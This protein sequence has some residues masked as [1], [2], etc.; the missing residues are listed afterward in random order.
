MALT[1]VV[2]FLLVALLSWRFGVSRKAASALRTERDDL[3]SRLD[4]LRAAKDDNDAL[5]AQQIASLH[6]RL[7]AAEKD[8]NSLA[9]FVNIRDTA[10][11]ADRI[12]SEAAATLAAAENKAAES[13]AAARQEAARVTLEATAEAKQKRTEADLTIARASAQAAKVIDD[14]R[15][16]AEEIAGD[17]LRAVEDAD[18]LT[19]TAAAMKNVIDGYGDAYMIPAHSLLDEL[20][21]SYSHTE[22]GKQLK[23][24]RDYSKL[25]A[26]QN[27]AADCDYVEKHRRETA[28][29]FVVDAFN[30]KS[31]SVLSRAKLDNFGSLQQEIKDAAALVNH[32]GAAFKNAR[33]RKE[34]V[35]ARIEEL[36]WA[37]RAN[38]LREREK[39]EQRA[40]REQMR[41]EEKA[42]REYE[43]AMRDAAKEEELIRRAMEKAQGQIA[44][45]SDEQKAQ[46]EAQL[47]ELAE[48]L[49][50]AEE[51]N[52]RALSM[53]QQTKAGHVYII[54]NV[55]SFGEHVY[56]VGLTRRLE[57]MDRVRELGDASVPFAFD[58]H[59]MIWS[60]NAPELEH[61]LHQ[62]FVEA[63]VNKVNPRKEFFRVGLADLRATVEEMGLNVSWTM[64]AAAAEY[65]ESLVIARQIEAD[66]T[67][68]DRWFRQQIAL[69]AAMADEEGTLAEVQAA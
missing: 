35:D 60:D 3:T 15:K 26:T 31:D 34:Y 49:Q 4:K 29:R 22:A 46:Y 27:R 30:G 10:A 6:E 52:Q 44:R 1:L 41:E 55:G 21:D 57:P 25:M 18:R 38:E 66:P 23:V 48:K 17:A 36:V 67:Q 58:V 40:I 16:R 47:A 14:A 28:I 9:R 19:A 7:A 63:Q 20:A 54:S 12:T 64:T 59:A 62:K 37:V 33:I 11:E 8:R 45:A 53:A 32:N 69:D 43:R 2:L 24:A 51:K 39:E 68:R 50:Q 5:N 61:T 13:L 42:R 65:R 56:K